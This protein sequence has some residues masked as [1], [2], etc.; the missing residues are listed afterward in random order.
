MVFPKN[1]S[2]QSYPKTNKRN[3]EFK[4]YFGFQNSQSVYMGMFCFIFY[5]SDLRLLG[6]LWAI[7]FLLASKSIPLI[8]S[9]TPDTYSRAARHGFSGPMIL[10]EKFDFF[11]LFFLFCFDFSAQ[12]VKLNPPSTRFDKLAVLNF[13]F[14]FLLKSKNA[15]IIF[16][17]NCTRDW[18]N[19]LVIQLFMH[20]PI[21]SIHFPINSI[22]F[23]LNS[24]RVK[25]GVKMWPRLTSKYCLF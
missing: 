10:L 3:L 24:I 22:H 7:Y 1:I 5:Y 13:T 14:C 20:F 19:I 23:P 12:I 18:Q 11:S 16:L 9:N 25:N 17:L 2:R 8:E 21:N 15:W 4:A 6:G